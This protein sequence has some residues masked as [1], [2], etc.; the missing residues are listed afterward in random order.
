MSLGRTFRFTEKTRFEIRAE[1]SNVFN[2]SA[3]GNPSAT[4][5]DATPTYFPNGN[6]AAGFGR[7]DATSSATGTATSTQVNLQP[8]SGTLVGR[9]VF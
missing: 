8:R 6:T 9:F 4:N 3:F 1:F 5:A 2:R 7:I